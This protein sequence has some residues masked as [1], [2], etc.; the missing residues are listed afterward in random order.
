MQCQSELD[1][2]TAV[3]GTDDCGVR[4]PGEIDD[5]LCRTNQDQHRDRAFA[6]IVADDMRSQ[7]RDHL[8][9][10]KF[11]GQEHGVAEEQRSGSRVRAVEDRDG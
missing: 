2:R 5:E 8:T 1:L 10:A 3:A 4:L 11:A 9:P 7:C 6:A